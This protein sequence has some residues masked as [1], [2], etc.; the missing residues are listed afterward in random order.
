MYV[1]PLYILYESFLTLENWIYVH[2]SCS[3]L[4]NF[5]SFSLLQLYIVI[6]E[7]GVV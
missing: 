3:Y 4:T 6:Y 5:V 1:D 2:N 7:V